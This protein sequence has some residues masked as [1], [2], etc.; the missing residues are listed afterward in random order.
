MYFVETGLGELFKPRDQNKPPPRD[1]RPNPRGKYLRKRYRKDR[2]IIFLKSI[3]T[4]ICGFPLEKSS[5]P[6]LRKWQRRSAGML[7][8]TRRQ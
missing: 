4:G 8:R 7:Q 6:S 5:K 1:N 2:Q 3:H